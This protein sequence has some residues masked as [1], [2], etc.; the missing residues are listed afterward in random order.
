[1]FINDD[2][3]SSAFG[4]SDITNTK[5]V[6]H[7]LVDILQVDI[8]SIDSGDVDN[9][10][11]KKYRVFTTG[12]LDDSDVLVVSSLYQTVFDQAHTLQ[13]SNELLD[14]TVGLHEKS[15]TVVDTSP[16]TDAE[17]KLIFSTTTTMM[18]REKVNMYQL[19]AQ[20]LLG[21]SNAYFTSP[22]GE[23]LVED[24][25]GA[26]KDN[27]IL[28]AVFIN[29]KRL[30]TR[31][32]ISTSS[33]AINLSET[34]DGLF[35]GATVP[36]SFSTISDSSSDPVTN[37]IVGGDVGT[38]INSSGAKIGLIFYQKGVVVLDARKIFNQDTDTFSGLI[39]ESYE[40][41]GTRLHTVNGISFQG[42][43]TLGTIDDILD[44][45][46]VT[47]LGRG[48]TAALAFRNKT[49]INS[50]IYFCKAPPN[51]FNY[52]TNPTFKDE[53]GAVRTINEEDPD[54]SP[55]TYITTIGLYNDTNDLLAIAKTSRPIKKDDVTDLSIRVKLDF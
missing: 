13:T 51:K 3:T 21:D 42:L 19:Y 37:T 10:T 29:I 1:M 7:Q 22:Y 46:C 31:D 38:L 41:S 18:M 52:S 44:H 55:F 32:E 53:N 5:K 11:R 50:T 45:I 35:E 15:K 8:S 23:V 40:N 16:T 47:R 24:A 27:A 48:N 20:E 4:T 17:G 36:T 25:G 2:K 28:E 39:N 54:P 14:F 12:S 30:F 26:W 9:N 6:V 34:S 33:F 43:L 49:F